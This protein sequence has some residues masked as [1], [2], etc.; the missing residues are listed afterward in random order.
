[1][2]A[3]GRQRKRRIIPN[4]AEEVTFTKKRKENEK[5]LPQETVHTTP[6]PSSA[7]SGKVRSLEVTQDNEI[8]IS[9]FSCVIP[10]QENRTVQWLE[11]A[12]A[13]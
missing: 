10:H 8:G 1:M 13:L 3:F 9:I 4:N 7:A 11:F 6:N 12:L 2:S 5:P